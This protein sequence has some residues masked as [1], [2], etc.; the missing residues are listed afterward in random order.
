MATYWDV[1]D[2]VRTVVQGL[3]GL[4]G[5]EVSINKW[6][7]FNPLMGSIRGVLIAPND[8]L[9]EKIAELQFD[10]NCWKDYEVFVIVVAEARFDEETIKWRM[11]RR[12]DIWNAL[13]KPT[14]LVASVSDE[15]DVKYDPEPGGVDG[16]SFPETLDWTAMK[17][18][19]RT[20][21]ARPS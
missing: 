6:P 5:A 18:T 13:F 20:S 11:D 16:A 2:A 19:Y 15:F 10:A 3:S 12:S 1:L 14:A 21:E 9:A 4:D 8:R 17:F 7:G